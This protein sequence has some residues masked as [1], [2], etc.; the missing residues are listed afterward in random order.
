M[1]FCKLQILDIMN[2][3]HRIIKLFFLIS[4]E[5]NMKF[6]TFWNVSEI[7]MIH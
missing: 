2:N 6:E 3:E 5:N 1:E 4:T 7:G